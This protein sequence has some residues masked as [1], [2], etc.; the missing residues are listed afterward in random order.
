MRSSP[1]LTFAVFFSLVAGCSCNGDR[2][3]SSP[4]NP[5]QKVGRER[6]DFRDRT[7]LIPSDPGQVV[8]VL[9][10]LDVQ[11]DTSP[12]HPSLGVSLGDMLR[13][14]QVAVISGV[15]EIDG[16]EYI[17]TAVKRVQSDVRSGEEVFRVSALRSSLPPRCIDLRVQAALRWKSYE[18]Q[19]K[20]LCVKDVASGGSVEAREFAPGE[21]HLE[22]SAQP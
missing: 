19:G 10:S 18:E 21:Y 13:S 3:A 20:E 15:D 4:A 7:V 11:Y 8:F 2:S 14:E 17:R 9:L 16:D 6:R 5:A 22:V 12:T 1:Q